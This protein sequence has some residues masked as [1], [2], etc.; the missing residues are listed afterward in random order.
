M[1]PADKLKASAEPCN[2]GHTLRHHQVPVYLDV[3]APHFEFFIFFFINIQW[4][5]I[6]NHSFFFYKKKLDCEDALKWIFWFGWTNDRENRWPLGVWCWKVPG[7]DSSCSADLFV[8]PEKRFRSSPELLIVP[9]CLAFFFLPWE[10]LSL[11]YSCFQ[12]DRPFREFIIPFLLLQKCSGNILSFRVQIQL[13]LDR[14]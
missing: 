5:K 6:P 10:A 8:P 13:S 14:T 12:L 4:I 7:S 2:L 9:A 1:H 3:H 11:Y